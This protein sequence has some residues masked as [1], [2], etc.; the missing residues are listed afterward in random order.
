MH[1]VMNDKKPTLRQKWNGLKEYCMEPKTR[2]DV[3][4]WAKALIRILLTTGFLVLLAKYI[5]E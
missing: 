3:K 1:C 2:F 4:D 5:M